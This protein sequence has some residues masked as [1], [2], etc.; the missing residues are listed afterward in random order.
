M[1]DMKPCAKM[2]SRILLLTL[3]FSVFITRLAFSQGI[4]I[5]HS[6]ANDP[7]TEGFSANIQGQAS[8]VLNDLGMDAWATTASSPNKGVIYTYFLTSQ[9][10]TALEGED[11]SLSITLRI[12]LNGVAGFGNTFMDFFTGSE[13]F[14]LAFAFASN[15]DPIVGAGPQVYTLNN[16][17][18]TYNNYQLVY[19]A[20][21]DTGSLLVNGTAQINN[22]IG[23]HGT[24]VGSV[25][26]GE[27]QQGIGQGNWNLLSLTVTPEPSAVSLIVLG[28]GIL[29]YVRRRK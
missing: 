21:T 1:K 28:S 25:I 8:S 22:I 12:P 3:I 16:A 20:A 7:T 17:G 10:Q 29:F 11:W 2:V 27:G 13:G 18:S 19:S 9:Q 24:G 6:G 5:Q 4:I 14:S 15:G 23:Q 26:W